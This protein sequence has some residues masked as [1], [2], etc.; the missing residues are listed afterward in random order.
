MAVKVR[1]LDRSDLNSLGLSGIEESGLNFF[2]VVKHD[3]EHAH[4]TTDLRPELHRL[5][6]AVLVGEVR[7]ILSARLLS[8]RDLELPREVKITKHET[9]RG[10]FQVIA[11]GN[12]VPSA[13]AAADHWGSGAISDMVI[14]VVDAGQVEPATSSFARGDLSSAL[15]HCSV[16]LINLGD[17]DAAI[18]GVRPANQRLV[19]DAVAGQD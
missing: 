16:G 19:L 8:T 11:S 4:R 18:V 7:W 17:W 15:S 1:P 5:L 12:D 2:D 10:W 14:A 9:E 13:K 3:T 6:Q